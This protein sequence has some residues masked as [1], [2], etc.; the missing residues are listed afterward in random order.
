LLEFRDG[1]PG[2]NAAATDHS[3]SY[4]VAH[5]KLSGRNAATQSGWLGGARRAKGSGRQVNREGGAFSRAG[6]DMQRAFGLFDESLDNAQPEAGALRLRLGGKEGLKNPRQQFHRDARAIVADGDGQ[7]R[8]GVLEMLDI[9][10]SLLRSVTELPQVQRLGHGG[11][12]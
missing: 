8:R 7:E 11:G 1:P 4:L 9:K 10:S 3:P 6:A 2:G 12:A 5:V